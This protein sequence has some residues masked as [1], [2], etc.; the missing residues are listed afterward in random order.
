MIR[1]MKETKTLKPGASYLFTKE[2][3]GINVWFPRNQIKWTIQSGLRILG[4]ILLPVG[5]VLAFTMVNN[6]LMI[7][8]R[9]Y[10]EE[11]LEKVPRQSKHQ[12]YELTSKDQAKYLSGELPP[13]AQKNALTYLGYDFGKILRKRVA[14]FLQSL[15][16]QYNRQY[17]RKDRLSARYTGIFELE[18]EEEIKRVL[19]E[20]Q[21]APL[22]H[23]D[24]RTLEECNTN[25]FHLEDPMVSRVISYQQVKELF[26]GSLHAFQEAA[27]EVRK[28]LMG[29]KQAFQYLTQVPP[30]RYLETG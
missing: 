19:A 6:K 4:I 14:S 18:T 23:S 25:S 3:L 27:R 20:M 15:T 26:G 11:V 1:E 21:N 16:I 28:K 29:M 9:F 8:I 13:I 17:K 7:L 30:G 24:K 10:S 2:I 22:V 5:D 12:A